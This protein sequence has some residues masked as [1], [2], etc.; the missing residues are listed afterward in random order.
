MLV[1]VILLLIS[2]VLLGYLY[3]RQTEELEKHRKEAKVMQDMLESQKKDLELQLNDMVV[4]YD[5]LKS[6]NDSMN[7]KIE[8]QQLKIKR[9]LSIN[10]SNLEKITLYK[11]ELGT[12]REIMRSYIVQIDSLNQRNQQLMAEN[13]EVRH[14]MRRVENEKEELT[15]QKEE[16]S[17]K[18]ELASVLSAKNIYAA[19]LSKR[20]KEKPKADKVDKIRV[21]FTVRENKVIT[22]GPKEIYIRIIRP[23]DVLLASSNSD[24]FPVGGEQLIFSAKRELEYENKDIDMCI[25]WDNTSSLIPGTYRV[26]LYSEGYEIGSTTFAL[27]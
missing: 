17:S 24:V 11:K 1:L 12:L 6:D 20:S 7:L 3:F 5:D 22:A 15:K 13:R 18:V 10:A 4:E 14:Q 2:T 16:L 21:C 23:D 26:Y 19:P 27:K 9:L 8:Q 25:Y